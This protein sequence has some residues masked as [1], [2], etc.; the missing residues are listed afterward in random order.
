M[1]TFFLGRWHANKA[2]GTLPQSSL[3]LHPIPIFLS[4][5]SPR[6]LNCP[7]QPVPHC[8][9]TAS[10]KCCAQH[11]AWGT[12]QAHW[13]VERSVGREGSDS[14]PTTDGNWPLKAVFTVMYAHIHMHIFAHTHIYGIYVYIHISVRFTPSSTPQSHFAISFRPSVPYPRYFFTLS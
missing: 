1:A 8:H 4:F 5:H 12:H 6:F 11:V 7:L 9:H 13:G 2:D 10:R 14:S 3:N